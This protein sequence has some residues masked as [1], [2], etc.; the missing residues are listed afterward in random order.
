MDFY[1]DTEPW[2]F[3]NYQY[4]PWDDCMRVKVK[5]PMKTAML[6]LAD[7]VYQIWKAGNG[8]P[9][10]VTNI[11]TQFERSVYSQYQKYRKGDGVKKDKQKKFKNLKDLSSHL[12]GKVLDIQ[13]PPLLVTLLHSP[14]RLSQVIMFGNKQ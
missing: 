6:E 4:L 12:Q 2:M 7:T 8:C 14:M 10:S 9:K 11:I 5:V 13:V 3:P 1:M